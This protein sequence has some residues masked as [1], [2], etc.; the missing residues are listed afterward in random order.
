MVIFRSCADN[1]LGGN[2]DMGYVVPP[3]KILGGIVPPCP[4]LGLRQWMPAIVQTSK[5]IQPIQY[6]LHAQPMLCL[7]IAQIL[8]LCCYW[9]T[10]HACCTL[11]IG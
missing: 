2:G 1:L 11:H 7:L 6:M 3:P 4:P 8:F 10:L 9:Q 5:F